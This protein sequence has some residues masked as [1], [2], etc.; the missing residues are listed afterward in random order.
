[1]SRSTLTLDD[2]HLSGPRIPR[3]DT[4]HLESPSEPRQRRRT[5]LLVRYVFIVTVGALAILRETGALSALN[6]A[7]VLG[8]L[9]S[10][11]L[12]SRLGS[13]IFFRWWIQGPVLLIDTAWISVILLSADLG[14]QF[15]LFYFILL[16]LV[17]IS[18]S[19]GLLVIGA[20][21]IGTVCVALDSDQALTSAS[22][23]RLPFFFATA[24]FYGYV[25]DLLKGERKI[26]AERAAWAQALE[27]QVRLR[28]AALERQSGEL[29]AL[30]DRLVDANRVRSEFIAN[31]SHELRTPLNAIAGY[32][33][34][35][36]ER[37]A[38]QADPDSKRFV[39]RINAS[40]RA[41][42]RLVENVLEYARLDRGYVKVL[43]TR[44]AADKLLAELEDLGQDLLVN[45]EVTL[46]VA[47]APGL[48]LQTDYDRLYSV[49]SNLLMNAI[50]F[51]SK[52]RVELS[53][54]SNRDEAT[55]VIRDSGV[56]IDPQRLDQLFEPFRQLDGSLKR[57]YGG[58]GLGLS[59]ARRNVQLLL[60]TIEV[61]SVPSQGS[62]FRVRIPSHLTVRTG[63]G[64]P[65]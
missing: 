25:V 63:A 26:A 16:F 9:L 18:E 7:L 1:M 53:I 32:S 5:Y 39:Q 51:T 38:I 2:S 20:I 50:K 65:G 11:V 45:P 3:V 33:D 24:V 29:R 62:T 46:Q 12:L 59:I 57:R 8:A 48:E 35:L 10:N 54:E 23:I 61:E 58:V 56:G 41:L 47:R 42:H 36:L 43:P 49:L 52:G 28:T 31:V 21:L 64:T 30:Y 13:D 44:F 14:Q 6:T 27:E 40:S 15:F 55:F 34:L 60:G 4:G 22:L 37:S 19:L 17:A